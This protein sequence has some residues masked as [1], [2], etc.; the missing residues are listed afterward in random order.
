MSKFENLSKLEKVHKIVE[1]ECDE[2]LLKH[3]IVYV[4]K[5]SKLLAEKLDADKEAAELVELGALLHDIGIVKH[6]N[7]DHEKTGIAE[8]ERILKSVG[9]P[10]N[11]I[12]EVKH[13]VESHRGS[14]DIKPTT[15]TAKIVANAD[16]MAHFSTIPHLMKIALKNENGDSEKA[17]HWIFDKIERD[18]NKKLTIPEARKMM[19][20]KYEAIKIL[21]SQDA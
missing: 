12:D 1:H 4:V 3:H 5:Y 13:C 11:I 15:I 10:Q 18:W 14:K 2:W 17:R 7:E 9:Y 19:K 8:A 16:A 20:K 6:G 21:F